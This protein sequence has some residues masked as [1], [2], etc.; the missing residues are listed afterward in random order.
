MPGKEYSMNNVYVLEPDREL[1]LMLQD[2][3]EY[4]GYSVGICDHSGLFLI[5]IGTENPAL[6]IV[7]MDHNNYDALDLLQKLRNAYYDLPIILWSW[8]CDQGDDLRAIAADYIVAKQ[9]DLTEL[10]RRMRMALDSLW[11]S[12]PAAMTFVCG[13]PYAGR[14]KYRPI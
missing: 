4:S 12:Q 8:N 5:N 13:E 7:D 14:G 9:P 2:E 6:V 3:L 1:A 11:P 10:K